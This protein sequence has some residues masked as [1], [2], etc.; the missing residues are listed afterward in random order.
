VLP[1]THFL[2]IV[3]G[4]VLRGA[5]LRDVLSEVEALL[6]FFSIAFTLAVLRFRKRLD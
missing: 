4:I 5:M 6:I 2:R 1:L 3:R